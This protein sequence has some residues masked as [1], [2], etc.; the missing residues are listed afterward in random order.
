MEST[1]TK[2]VDVSTNFVVGH[3]ETLPQTVIAKPPA[4]MKAPE[5]AQVKFEY[6]S[7]GVIS[8]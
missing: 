7:F 1:R 3:V 4:I 2:T 6:I 5:K 8:S